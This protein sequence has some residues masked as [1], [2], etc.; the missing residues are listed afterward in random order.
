MDALLDGWQRQRRLNGED[1]AQQTV[2]L[3]L[4][5]QARGPLRHL[6]GWMARVGWHLYQ[7]DFSDAVRY[8][9]WT[10][11]HRRAGSSGA[12]LLE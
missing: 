4:E 8:T 6:Y 7:A 1:I 10:R 12:D 11:S 2:L 3:C 9:G 5:R